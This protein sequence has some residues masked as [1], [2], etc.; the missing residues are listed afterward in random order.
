M[1]R[2]LLVILLVT[3]LAGCRAVATESQDERRTVRML[4]PDLRAALGRASDD[5]GFTFEITSGWRS[6]AHQER[7]FD[8]AVVTYGSAAEAARWVAHP[9]TSVHE[10]GDAVDIGPDRAIAWLSRHGSRFG[11]CQIYAN[12][13]WHYELRPDA[14]DEGCPPAYP[15]PTYDPRMQ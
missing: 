2:L 12:E 9:G 7:L 8:E 14:V 15:D 10:S 11:L 5:A 6:R 1:F 4:D 13:P 3:G